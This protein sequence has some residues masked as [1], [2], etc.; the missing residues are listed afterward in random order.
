MPRLPQKFS[1]SVV[2]VGL[3]RRSEVTTN[4]RPWWVETRARLLMLLRRHRIVLWR[5]IVEGR[6]LADVV[7]ELGINANS[8]AAL[9]HRA[10]RAPWVSY[11]SGMRSTAG[12]VAADVREFRAAR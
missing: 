3:P 2:R 6:E 8:A 10:K 5:T 11:E 1:N 12:A 4:W 9:A 7:D